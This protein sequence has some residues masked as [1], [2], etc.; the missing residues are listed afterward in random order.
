MDTEVS[1]II[2]I[3]TIID[4]KINLLVKN[5]NSIINIE[6]L[7]DLDSVCMKYINENLKIEDLKLDQYYTFSD[8]QEN[9]KLSILYIGIINKDSISLNNSFKFIELNNLNCNNKY[10]YKSI[11]YLKKNLVLSNV[12]KKVFSNLFILPELQKT[13]ENLFNI[14]YDRRNFR[15]RLVK[16]DI[17]E[18]SNTYSDGKNGRPAKLYKFK[19]IEDNI[20]II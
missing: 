13:Y 15:K 5:D 20:M 14:K 8:K 1:C 19:N 12:I 6:C 11:E 10:I 17:I 7:D 9:L 18:D 4:S 3:F 2:N 16:L